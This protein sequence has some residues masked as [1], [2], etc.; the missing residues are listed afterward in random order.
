MKLSVIIPNYNSSKYL[1]RCLDSVINQTYK[2][3]E[4]IIINDGSTDDSIKI[5]NEYSEKDKRIKIID[6]E[7]KGVSFS[8]NVG[9]DI[10]TGELI[11]FVDADDEIDQ[12]MYEIM[13]QNLKKF[14]ASISACDSYRI[15]NGKVVYSGINDKKVFLVENP[16]VD[17]LLGKSLKYGPCNKVFKREIIGDTR[18]NTGLTN[19]EDRLFLYEIYKK[20]PLV[21]KINIPKYKYYLN[22]NSASSSSF[23]EKHFSILT[24]ADMIYGDAKNNYPDEANKYLFENLIVFERKLAISTD[25]IEYL[26]YY[27]NVRVK[28]IY[29]S[30]KIK[31]NGKRKLEILILKY[32]KKL[33]PFFVK[34]IIK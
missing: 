8:R 20:N 3:L 16:V 5:L 25:K 18:F 15:V 2:D 24:S 28:L 14:D 1:R 11:A 22:S 12:D 7:N 6:Q 31:L 13:V 33:Y 34:K 17:F 26:D 27:N 19:S 23:N 10:S 29:L 21:V 32:F 9:L 4:I 30:K